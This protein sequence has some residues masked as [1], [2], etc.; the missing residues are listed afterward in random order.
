MT[1]GRLYKKPL[2]RQ[3]T[4][5]Q[6]QKNAGSQFDPNLIDIFIKIVERLSPNSIDGSKELPADSAVLLPIG[7][8]SS[9]QE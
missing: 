3:E 9:S 1:Y 4:L 8:G 6:L 5:Q 2:N 7:G